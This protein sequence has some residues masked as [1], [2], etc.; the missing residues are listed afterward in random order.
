M[1]G[2]PAPKKNLSA[3]KRARQ[4]EKLRLRNR[5]VLTLIKTV[6]KRVMSA[7][8]AKNREEVQKAFIEA[9]RVISKAVTKGIIHKNM[10]SRRISRLARIANT[11][12]RPEAA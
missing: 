7:V 1:P 12:L 6:T 5:A 3:L 4:A 11:I 2:K 10:A 8:D 9:T